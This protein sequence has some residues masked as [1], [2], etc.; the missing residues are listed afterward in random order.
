MVLQYCTRV[1]ALPVLSGAQK[2]GLFQDRHHIAGTLQPVKRH[3]IP[4]R[5]KRRWILQEPGGKV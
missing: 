5:Q 3:F 2:V 1:L 4:Q